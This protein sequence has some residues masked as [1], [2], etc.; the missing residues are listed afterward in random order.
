MLQLHSLEHRVSFRLERSPDTA[1]QEKIMALVEG[2]SCGTGTISPVDIAKR[3]GSANL[4]E[5]SFESEVIFSPDALQSLN[6]LPASSI[7]V[8][9][10]WNC[11]QSH[12]VPVSLVVI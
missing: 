11:S 5:I 6:E 2:C 9:W 4:V 3:V 8:S 1:S 12:Q 10:R 7:P